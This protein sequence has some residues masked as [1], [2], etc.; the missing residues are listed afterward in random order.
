MV[1]IK[2]EWREM[3]SIGFIWQEP[4][5]VHQKKFTPNILIFYITLIYFYYYLN[6]K[7][8]TK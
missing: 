5:T 6:K 8:T 2:E 3:K 4:F 7:I 1:D